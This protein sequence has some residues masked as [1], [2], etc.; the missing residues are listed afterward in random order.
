M[1][2]IFLFFIIFAAAPT[3]L[4]A[5]QKNTP[6]Q[7]GNPVSLE[8]ITHYGM[9]IKEITRSFK[10]KD[11]T[12]EIIYSKM[13]SD[14]NMDNYVKRFYNELLRQIKAWLLTGTLPAQNVRI[15]I[16]NCKFCKIGY[17]N[18][19]NVKEISL[20]LYTNDKEKKDIA[21]KHAEVIDGIRY[22]TLA[23]RVIGLFLEN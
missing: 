6:A 13:L 7:I 18:K 3:I 2:K 19:K 14:D 17:C 22:V 9:P 12:L 15:V 10:Q 8:G 20:V 16:S 1:K 23:R 5:E 21:F 11:A 4:I